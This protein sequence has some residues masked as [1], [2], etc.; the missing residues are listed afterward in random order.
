[1]RTEKLSNIK[2]QFKFWACK[3]PIKGVDDGNY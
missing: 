2:L 1:M 3:T